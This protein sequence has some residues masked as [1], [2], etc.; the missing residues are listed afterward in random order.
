MKEPRGFG[1]MVNL[2]SIR[3]WWIRQVD[4]P[5][6]YWMKELVASVDQFTALVT[7]NAQAGTLRELAVFSELLLIIPHGCLSSLTQLE[8][9]FPTRMARV[10]EVDIVHALRSVS[11]M[12]ACMNFDD[13]ANV[14]CAYPESLPH[15]RAFKLV[16]LDPD[17]EEAGVYALIAFLDHKPD[18]RRVDTNLPGFGCNAMS[19]LVQCMRRLHRLEMLVIDIRTMVEPEQ[20]TEFDMSLPPNLVALHV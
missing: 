12:L 1:Q 7:S 5:R 2:Q 9:W 13:I 17:I 11:L 10:A 6:S 3:L 15:L 4:S 8:V 20:V 16:S 18:I 14:L 19:A